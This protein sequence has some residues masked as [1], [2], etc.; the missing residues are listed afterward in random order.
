MWICWRSSRSQSFFISVSLENDE[1]YNI[2]KRRHAKYTMVVCDQYPIRTLLTY[3]RINNISIYT[4]SCTSTKIHFSFLSFWSL[5]V[6]SSLTTWRSPLRTHWPVTSQRSRPSS[7]S[8][9]LA[10]LFRWELSPSSAS[11]WAL[12]WW[13]AGG[14]MDSLCSVPKTNDSFPSLSQ[15]ILLTTSLKN[16]HLID[17]GIDCC[18]ACTVF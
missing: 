17:R 12:T 14:E 2:K 18:Q 1:D 11:T 13:E 3:P 8:S 15:S 7:S 10:F 5:Q 6:A 9:L 16:D 4:K